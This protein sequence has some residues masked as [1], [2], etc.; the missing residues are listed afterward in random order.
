MKARWNNT[1]VC[2]RGRK[3]FRGQK[4]RIVLPEY[5]KKSSN[6]DTDEATS[7]S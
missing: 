7:A 2:E 1:F 4:Q 3:T 6:I 5:S